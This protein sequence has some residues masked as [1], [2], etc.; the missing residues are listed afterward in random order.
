[1]NIYRKSKSNIRKFK[2]KCPF[3]DEII[4]ISDT[5][6]FQTPILFFESPGRSLENATIFSDCR[7]SACKNE[8]KPDVG[9]VYVLQKRKFQD[10]TKKGTLFCGYSKC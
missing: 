3:Y 9:D 8:Y 5:A 1:M 10:K 7:T 6:S 2:F 4:T